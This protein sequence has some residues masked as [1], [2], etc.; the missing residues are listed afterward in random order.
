[1][2]TNKVGTRRNFLYSGYEV[3]LYILRL[4]HNAQVFYGQPSY[5]VSTVCIY[6]VKTYIP[7]GMTT[8]FFITVKNNRGKFPYI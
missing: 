7:H 3:K 5:Y 2:S 6:A 4:A 1:M 8:E